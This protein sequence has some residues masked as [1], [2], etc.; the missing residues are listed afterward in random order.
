MAFVM[1]LTPAAV[2]RTPAVERKELPAAEQTSTVERAESAEIP[3][4]ER[5]IL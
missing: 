1:A 2:E 5:A 3:A 4:V